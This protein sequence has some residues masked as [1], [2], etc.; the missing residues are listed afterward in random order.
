MG[1]QQWALIND[2]GNLETIKIPLRGGL[3]RIFP[4]FW[5]R[6]D[7]RVCLASHPGSDGWRI[8]KVSAIVTKL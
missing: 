7:A 6:K 3:C 5:S 8:E 4:L 1:K 2:K